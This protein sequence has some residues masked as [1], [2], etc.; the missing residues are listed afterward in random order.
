VCPKTVAEKQFCTPGP[1]AEAFIT[2][3]AAAG[4][5][6]LGPELAELNTRTPRTAA[7]HS[8][9]CSAGRSR[10]AAGAR[11]MCVP[12]SPL[13]P[14]RQSRQP[15]GNALVLE[16]RGRMRTTHHPWL[17][18]HTTTVCDGDNES[19]LVMQDIEGYKFCLD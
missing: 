14:G 3:A 1:V 16:L 8:W 2:G 7:M 6:R 13:A 12:F 11:A 10:S 18:T 19:R 5:I 4:N 17:G 15:A 9:P